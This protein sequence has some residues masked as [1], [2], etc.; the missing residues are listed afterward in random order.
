[1]EIRRMSL[2][3][4]CSTRL[5]VKQVKTDYYFITNLVDN[6]GIVNFTFDKAV[7]S[8]ILDNATT[9]VWTSPCLDTSAILR[10]CH[11]NIPTQI[12]TVLSR[13]WWWHTWRAHFQQCRTFLG[14]VPVNYWMN[15]SKYQYLYSIFR[16]VYPTEIPLRKCFSVASNDQTWN[17]STEN[18]YNQGFPQVHL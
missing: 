14:I 9:H 3:R 18:Q 11:F 10:I 6:D 15:S 17:R 12:F 1:M 2:H 8:N 7:K 4:S 13:V 16:L 5:C